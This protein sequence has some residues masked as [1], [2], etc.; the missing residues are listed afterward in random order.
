[1]PAKSPK[2]SRPHMPGYGVPKTSKGL[3]AWSWGEQRLK[4][5]HNYWISTA[6]PDGSPHLM[7]IWGLW[8]DGAFLFS[9]GAQSRKGKNLAH[10]PQCVIGTEHAEQAVVVEGEA[11]LV[12]D[13]KTLKRFA[14]LYQ[15]K[16]DWDMSDLSEPVYMVRPRVGFG[17]YEKNFMGSATRWRF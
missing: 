1:M 17:L 16:Y 5:S 3:L 4:K 12:R 8:L 11:R 15:K 10:S 13:S 14:A 7:V 9:T 2:A 6:R